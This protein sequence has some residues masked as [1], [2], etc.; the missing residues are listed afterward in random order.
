MF[1]VP[2]LNNLILF[3]STGAACIENG[4]T[5]QG[6]KQRRGGRTH[7]AKLQ[8]LNND[9]PEMGREEMGIYDPEMVVDGT[10]SDDDVMEVENLE[11][12]NDDF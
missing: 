2:Q 12:P 9:E 10:F 6:E 1:L 3:H 5:I 11:N 4:V 7:G 8:M